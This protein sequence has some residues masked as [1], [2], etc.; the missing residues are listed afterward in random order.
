[1]VHH[2]VAIVG[3]DQQVQVADR[4]TATS[5]TTGPFH[6]VLMPSQDSHHVTCRSLRAKASPLDQ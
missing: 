3:H 2:G 6:L 5:E 4:F 1:M